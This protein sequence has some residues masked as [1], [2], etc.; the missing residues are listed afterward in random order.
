[1]Q[2]KK[3]LIAVPLSMTLLTG[4]SLVEKL[5]YRIDINQGN[6]VEQQAVDQLKFG[7]T[8]EQVRFVMGSP[9]LI[10][11][12][13]PDTWYY[14]YHHTEGHQDSIQKNLIVNF[15]DKGQLVDING[16]FPPSSDF[17]EGIN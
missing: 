2:L 17:F 6:Y 12:G 5:V 4:C 8:K 1:M 7:M 3:W 14:I 11:N 13:Y 9:M 10:E 16:D 15:N